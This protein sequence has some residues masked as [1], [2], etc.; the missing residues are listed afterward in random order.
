MNSGAVLIQW[1]L[2]N[3]VNNVTN[4]QTPKPRFTAKQMLYT[5]HGFIST[6]IRE[7]K[8]KKIRHFMSCLDYIS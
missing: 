4:T 7:A 1:T 6:S 5:D 8:N 3:V 2:C